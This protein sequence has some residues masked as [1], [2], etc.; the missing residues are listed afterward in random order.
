MKF[1]FGILL[2]CCLPAAA[3]NLP[4][5]EII[6]ITNGRSIYVIG[7]YTES[8]VDNT[9]RLTINEVTSSKYSK[10]F[11]PE[12]TDIPSKRISQSAVWIRFSVINLSSADDW[13]LEINYPPLQK[14]DFYYKDS[15]DEY[16]VKRIG[17][18]Y[19]HS[20]WE[21]DERMPVLKLPA[22]KN[23]YS[24]FYLR[25][26][27]ETS[28]VLPMYILTESEFADSS[29]NS[30][31]LLGGYYGIILAML[32]YNLFLF[33]SIKERAYLY[34]VFYLLGYG[35]YQ[36]A[37]DGLGFQLIWPDS[38][39]WNLLSFM[40]F[41]GIYFTFGALFTK[42]F[43]KIGEKNGLLNLLLGFTIFWGI[44]ISAVVFLLPFPLIDR[45]AT[46]YSFLF[47][48]LLFGSGIYS[49][50]KGYKPARYYL[51]AITFLL[52]GVLLRALRIVG[53]IPMSFSA[54]YGWQV[55]SLLEMI[56]L[57]F[58]LGNKVK[59]ERQ[60]KRKEVEKVRGEI[61]SDLHDEIG[62]NLG[63][64][65]LM[66][67]R[68]I[69]CSD[70][71]PENRQQL[72]EAAETVYKTAESLRDIVWFIAPEHD[73]VEHTINHLNSVTGKLLQGIDYEFTVDSL[74]Y[75]KMNLRIHRYLY[76]MY[77]EILHNIVKH[78]GA[79]EVNINFRME[80]GSL[81]VSIKDNGKG[82]EIDS[83]ENGMGLKN[84]QKRAVIIGA[85]LQIIGRPKSGTEVTIRLGTNR[86][87]NTGSKS[88]LKIT[89]IFQ[90]KMHGL[91]A[92]LSRKL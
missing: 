17:T 30:Y 41:I 36:F 50:R 14:I 15:S 24:T 86:K 27:S 57:S 74:I 77:K 56:L 76:L 61:A 79:T 83:F 10:M 80:D 33:I 12:K 26:E 46:F 47:V 59:T 73:I 7:K 54:A 43:L 22:M 19:H 45:L 52:A 87:V 90:V 25:V 5:S 60:E 31:F 11:K 16:R 37:I 68:T 71:P 75:Q 2:I 72:K 20:T 84:L 42:D 40:F 29:R 65:G 44:F 70:I 78:S 67:Q 64:I 91:Y 13:V 28:V 53:I 9:K 55:G 48:G 18:Y 66:L 3:E 34:Y 35:L 4:G 88:K 21:K 8:F 92:L 85:D 51:F 6:S 62:S 89:G 23:M 69:K 82:I 49:L 81:V 32:L 1:W 63:S 39:R 38:P 58:A